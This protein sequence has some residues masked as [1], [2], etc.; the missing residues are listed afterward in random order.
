MKS[1]LLFCS[2]IC[3]LTLA[4]YAQPNWEKKADFP[5]D[6]RSAASSF[7]FT[8][9]GYVGLGY[10]GE[11]F[12]RSFYAYDPIYDTWTQTES[13]GGAIGEGLERNTAA[14][15]TIGNFG[16]IATGQS[17][18]PFLNDCW[19]YDYTT[20][21]WTPEASVGGID[22]RGAVG[23]SVNGKGYVGLGQDAT[24]YKNDLWELDTTTGTWSQ[25]ADF[26][27]TARR[28]AIAFVIDGSAYVG[29]GDDGG[30]KNDFY[31]YKAA[32]NSWIVRTNFGGSPRYSATG[33]AL[34][35]KGYVA[36][37][38]DT[39]F[40]NQT[41]FWEYDPDG[42]EWIQ[43]ADFPGGPRANAIAFTVDTLAFFGMG[44]DTSFYYDIWLWG[45]TTDIIIQ[46]TTTAIQSWQNT[47]V[48]IQIFPN[49]ITHYSIVEIT[50]PEYNS[51]LHITII[52]MFGRD[53]SSSCNVSKT[54][55]SNGKYQ[56]RLENT[57][58]TPGNYQ[59]VISDK[60]VLGAQQ[61]LVL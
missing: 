21:S 18:D 54:A 14:S 39:T 44:Y 61:F 60:N 28:F 41:D 1:I 47:D 29:T 45:D 7:S 16:Y 38:Y 11:D 48:A 10:D 12:R 20:N 26:T 15:F 52:D 55:Y 22:R 57:H 32:T 5:G 9:F 8:D 46:D 27:G 53:V 49:P 58:L 13:L 56:F 4:S 40:T 37:G 17:G 35:G 30:F 51:D 43:L 2:S 24:G 50:M 31:E 59:F 25:Q 36:C 42:D 3:C 34:N 6:G 23:F 19:K 33:F